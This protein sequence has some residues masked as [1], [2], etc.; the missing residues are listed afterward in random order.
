MLTRYVRKLLGLA[1]APLTLTFY[2]ASP[3]M[4]SKIGC[5]GILVTKSRL[6]TED[7][8]LLNKRWPGWVNLNGK[9]DD[10]AKIAIDTAAQENT[11]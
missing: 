6:T 10:C 8:D 1:P 4:E 5:T 7:I 9:P 2:K 11:R 3:E